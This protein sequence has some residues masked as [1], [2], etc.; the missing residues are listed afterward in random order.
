MRNYL[1]HWK[2]GWAGQ[3]YLVSCILEDLDPRLHGSG[4]EPVQG[5]HQQCLPGQVGG[6][7][8]Q[9]THNPGEQ[10]KHLVSI[11]VLVTEMKIGPVG[12]I[13]MHFTTMKEEEDELNF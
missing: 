3:C 5:T 9:L 12:L 7:G 1:I 4:G 11:F 10:T 2:S 6:L 8:A 13:P